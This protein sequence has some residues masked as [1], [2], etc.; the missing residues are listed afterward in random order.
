MRHYSVVFNTEHGYR[1]SVRINNPNVGLP[2]EDI[3]AAAQQMIDNDVFGQGKGAL[4]SVNRME[5]TSIE[6]KVI[7]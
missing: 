1:R 5:L 7:I 2:L 4:E 3:Q 6:R